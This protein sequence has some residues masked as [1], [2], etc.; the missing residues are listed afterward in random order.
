MFCECNDNT[1]AVS[2][3]NILSRRDIVLGLATGSVALVTS[4]ST[5]SETGRQQIAFVS[6]SQLSQLSISAWQEMKTK[7]PISKDAKYRSR[8]VNVG[9]KVAAISNIQ[10]AAWEYEVFDSPQVNAFVLPGGKVGVYKGLLD[11]TENDDQLAC[12]LGHETGHVSGRHA[13]ERMSRGLL[14]QGALTVAQV[15]VAR[16][17]VSAGA[18]KDIMTALGLGVQYGIVL[19]FSRDQELEA[20]IIGLK[21]MQRAGY[22]PRQSIN[23]WQRMA[24]SSSG[25]PPEW[26]STHPSEQT[27]IQRL[28]EELKKMGYAV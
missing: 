9:S 10:N 26:L 16:T 27:R 22:D 8:V 5:N 17:S 20:D 25:K 2:T 6:D 14:A 11:L 19:P 12:V 23:L 15:G 7:L 3:K 28:S 4:C 13:S 1:K 21:Y 24:K 18:Q